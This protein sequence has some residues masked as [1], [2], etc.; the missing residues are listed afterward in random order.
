LATIGSS[1]TATIERDLT[2][3]WSRLLGCET[4]ASTSNFFD[5]GGHSLMAVQMHRALHD[6]IAPTLVLTD[7][8]RFPTI[9]TLAAHIA[10][11]QDLAVA[12]LPATAPRMNE[13]AR[14]AATRLAMTRRERSSLRGAGGQS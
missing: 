13:G 5:L 2:A 1:A 7:I 14:R 9:A 10:H 3:L 6:T 8:F 4:V 12:T 11:L